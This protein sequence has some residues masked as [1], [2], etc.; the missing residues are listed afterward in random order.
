MIEDVQS[1]DAA[2]I[3][4]RVARPLGQSADG[5]RC[6]AGCRSLRRGMIQKLAC[7]SVMA[8]ALLASHLPLRH[9]PCPARIHRGPP[10]RPL[11]DSLLGSLEVWATRPRPPQSLLPEG[12]LGR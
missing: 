12:I 4:T 3:K 2:P 5:E 6:S 10:A 8:T 11:L 7:V 9:P 1:A